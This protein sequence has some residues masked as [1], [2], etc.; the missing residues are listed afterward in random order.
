MQR[1]SSWRITILRD[2]LLRVSRIK[3]ITENMT[4]AGELL[5]VRL[6]EHLIVEKKGLCSF[7]NAV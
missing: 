5:F 2:S 7:V 4:M 3:C 1:G 6:L